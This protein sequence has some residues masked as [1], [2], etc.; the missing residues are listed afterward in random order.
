[1]RLPNEA[2]DSHRWLIGEIAPDFTLLD[3]WALPVGGRRDDFDAFLAALAFFDPAH[4]GTTLTRFLFWLRLRAG[5]LLGWDDPTKERRIPGC[6]ESSLA[7]R[8]PDALAD[9]AEDHAISNA[10]R[11][12]AGGFTPLYKTDDEWAAEIS[13]DTVHG[14]MHLAWVQQ[15]DGRY[16]AQMGV[17]V[18]PRGWFGRVYLKCIEPFRH[19]IVYPALTRQVGRMWRATVADVTP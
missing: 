9:T 19:L 18:K 17:Y 1:M 10:M 3:V 16:R 4:T 6:S 5:A 14:V 13:N 11:T 8:V 2:H 7:V 12:T 15:P